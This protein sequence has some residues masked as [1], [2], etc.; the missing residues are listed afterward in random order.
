M[1]FLARFRI[2]TKTLAVILLLSAVAGGIT[3]LGVRSLKSLSD[4]TDQMELASGQAVLA[5][6]M[7][8]NVV[9]MSRGEF[10]VAMDP[11]IENRTET[12][13]QVDEEK[14][15]FQT[16]LKDITAKADDATRRH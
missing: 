10:G 9:S 16:R 3:F 1:S 2:L 5:T 13:K 14:K 6:R 15:T 11:R 8:L 7:N 12:R 4:A